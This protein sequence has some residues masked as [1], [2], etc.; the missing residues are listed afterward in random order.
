[1]HKNYIHYLFILVVCW[2]AFFVNNSS[3][4]EDIM[5]SRNL[6]TAHEMIEYDNWLVP[7]MNGELRL[8]KPP[9][10]TWVA[11]GIE[12]LAPD[13]I[14]LQRAA[15]GVM[16]TLMAF[17][18]YFFASSL[19]GNRLLGL[20]SAL[21]LATSF[22]VIMAGRV[23]TWDIYCH[24]FM[25]G[26]IFF[27]YK[28][29]SSM[30]TGWGNFIWAG[31]FLG[32]SFLGKGP[33]SFYA[34]LFP[35]LISYFWVYRPSF[36]R[37]GGPIVVMLLL[38]VVISFW[39]PLYLYMF[40]RDT[41]MFVL[42]KEST[43]WIERNVR[44]WYY[45]WLFFA[46]S[47]I[48]SLFLLT[49][50]CWP[51]LKNKITLRK[52]YTLAVLWTVV[53]L[54]LLSLFPEKKTRYLLPLLIPAAMVVAHYVVY[55]FTATKEKTLT[56]GDR[57]MF[58][59]NAF[60]PALIALGMPVAVYLLFYTKEQVSLTLLIIVSIL[61]LATAYSI[62][63]GGVRMRSMKVFT[64]VVFLLILVETLLMSKV[65]NIFNNTEIKSIKAV[66]DIKELQHL[67]FYYPEKEGLRIELVYKAGRRILPWD[68]EKDTTILDS[69]PIVLVSEKPA[70]EVLP[71]TIQEKVNLHFIDVFDNN[72]RP[73]SDKKHYSSKFVRY[74]TM[75]EKK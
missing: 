75:L 46:E 66:R 44:P 37:K 64:G 52:E 18:L 29:V 57:V 8:E 1:M 33:V 13:N 27:F 25:L 62:F 17:F 47:G 48:W 10:P 60:L 56:T 14:S 40:H 68:I 67:P 45:Y 21:V 23:A 3:V 6:V 4:Y 9:L 65:A 11:A 31:I 50:L 63:T 54:V 12:Y 73:K 51:W 61:F 24:S 15:A 5:E 26:A 55:I 30:R 2:F 49:G 43:A 53:T 16:A 34:L 36:K 74:V 41:A 22:N 32:L 38:F 72:N 70:A 20:L 42:A 59:I 71:A 58:R 35:F 39:W 19:S 7:T 69:L 28:G